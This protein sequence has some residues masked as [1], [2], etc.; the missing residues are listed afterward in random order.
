MRRRKPKGWPSY[1]AEKKLASGHVAYYWQPPT[2]ARKTG[3]P[4][5]S[6][7]LGTDYA[8]AKRRCDDILNPHFHAW[9]RQDEV[10]ETSRPL[11][12]TFDWLVTVYKTSPKYLKLTP[13]TQADYDAVLSLVSRHMLQDGRSFGELFLKSIS[14]G[15]AN[16][17]HA[18]LVE[19]GRGN[20][21]RTAKLAMDVCRSAWRT[22]HR[23]K[24]TVVPLE[25]PF[26]QM[27]LS[28]RPKVTRAATYEELVAFVATAD[29]LRHRSLGTAALISF[30]WLQREEDIF[31]RLAWS[32][33]RAS[34]APNA[35][36][37]FH[38]KTG[39]L[40][41]VPL[42]DNDDSCLWPDLVPRLDS[43]P[44]V[45]TLLVMRDKPDRKCKLHLPWATSANNP[46][47]HVQRVV[48]KIRDAAGLPSDLTFTS[49]RHGGHTDAANAGLTDA[50]IRALSGHKT[51]AMVSLY[52]KATRDQRLVGARMRLEARRT[53]GG[54]LSE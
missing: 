34:D 2:W 49:F 16:R 29:T 52:A 51:T 25:N 46:V 50:Q 21:Q 43:E 35:V 53:N 27:G 41:E 44:R 8:E 22:A 37:I 28:Y 38:H 7:P 3:C 20:R 14:P 36:R 47:R 9:L 26:A 13:G 24:A 10:S 4:V 30:F 15:A 40:V 17:L 33:F 5:Q 42:H 19:G 45:G 11:R 23:D 39:E 32:H 54:N 31:L 6:E 1:M 12:C 48:A 18:K